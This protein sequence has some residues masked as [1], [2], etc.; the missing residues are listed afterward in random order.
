MSKRVWLRVAVCVGL[1]SVGSV[2]PGQAQD[3]DE[4]DEATELLK[5]GLPLTPE[6]TLS[7]SSGLPE[8]RIG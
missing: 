6:R 3:Q 4:V 2:A 1:L 8:R 5:E 7:G